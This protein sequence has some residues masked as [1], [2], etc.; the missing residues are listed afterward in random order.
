[1]NGK[2]TGKCNARVI[3]PRFLEGRRLLYYISR[4]ISPARDLKFLLDLTTKQPN[5]AQPFDIDIRKI[6]KRLL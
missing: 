2:I 1:M 4:Q 3:T 5:L 6:K